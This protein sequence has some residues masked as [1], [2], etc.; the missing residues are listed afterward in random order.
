MTAAS[1]GGQA[2]PTVGDHLEEHT[3]AAL[4]AA[5]KRLTD[6]ATP[7]AP[8]PQPSKARKRKN[9]KPAR[10]AP[11]SQAEQAKMHARWS[12]LLHRSDLTL[13]QRDELSALTKFFNKRRYEPAPTP[14]RPT[15]PMPYA[16]EVRGGLPGSGR[17]G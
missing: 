3:R 17:R 14:I 8:T 7:P 13:A 5:V 15:R 4:E 6:S 2:R 1:R 16:R 12:E 9:P 10:P 11:V